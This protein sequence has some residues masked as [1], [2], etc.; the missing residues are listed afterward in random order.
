M[1]VIGDVTRRTKV[2]PLPSGFSATF[3]DP[4]PPSERKW[5]SPE[6]PTAV[7][8]GIDTQQGSARP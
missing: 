7:M 6:G 1:A 5:I 4:V 8:I 2:I 3:G